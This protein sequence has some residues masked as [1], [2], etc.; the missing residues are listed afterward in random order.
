MNTFTMSTMTVTESKDA[1]KR[2]SRH[3]WAE[4]VEEADYLHHTEENKRIYAER[5]ET[6]ERV[7]AAMK[8]KNGDLALEDR[9]PSPNFSFVYL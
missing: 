7:F 5:K 8:L 2:I 4:Y 9:S 6:I 1:V 3:V